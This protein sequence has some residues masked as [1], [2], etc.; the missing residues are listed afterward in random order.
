MFLSREKQ[1]VATWMSSK[2]SAV[3]GVKNAPE[4]EIKGS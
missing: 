2:L 3:V 1:L 4:M